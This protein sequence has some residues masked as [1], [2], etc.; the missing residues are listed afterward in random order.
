M[1]APTTRR[2]EERAVHDRLEAIERAHAA[3]AN[4]NAHR[5]ADHIRDELARPLAEDCRCPITPHSTLEQLHGP[6]A[7]CTASQW[8]RPTPDALRRRLGA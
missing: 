5:R 1:T 3:N 8:V 2:G 7:G 6:G 4:T